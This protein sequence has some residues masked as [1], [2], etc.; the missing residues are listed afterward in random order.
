M[1]GQIHLP[2]SLVIFYSKGTYAK[3]CNRFV[4]CRVLRYPSILLIL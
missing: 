3:V 4:T 1:C 2:Q